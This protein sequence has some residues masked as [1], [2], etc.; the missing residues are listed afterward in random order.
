MPF[1]AQET[2]L[3]VLVAIG[4]TAALAD[5]GGRGH[6]RGIPNMNLGVAELHRAGAGVGPFVLSTVPG[7]AA[8]TPSHGL[9]PPGRLD[10]PGLRLGH[11]HSTGSPPGL[12]GTQNVLPPQGATESA[13][14]GNG[15]AL[16]HS[17]DK[18]GGKK[19]D[20]PS[21]SEAEAARIATT[22][23]SD[24]DPSTSSASSSRQIPTCR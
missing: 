20:V 2:L 3:A 23:G 12:T 21:I 15:L 13:Q 17:D 22:G 6:H 4:S 19:A 18:P 11:G 8:L 10:T 7:A 14:P 16:G 24:S 1:L 5:K 9:R